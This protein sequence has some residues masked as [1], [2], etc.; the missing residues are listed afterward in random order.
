MPL[1]DSQSSRDIDL[2]CLLITLFID[3]H[4]R[5]VAAVSGSFLNIT[6]NITEAK[7]KLNDVETTSIISWSFSLGSYSILVRLE[8]KIDF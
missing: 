6:L 4:K 7:V 1:W 5:R 2:L 3:L 8:A